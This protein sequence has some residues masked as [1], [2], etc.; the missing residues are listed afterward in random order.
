MYVKGASPFQTAPHLTYL[1]EL[2]RAFLQI[3]KKIW[4]TL[5]VYLYATFPLQHNT[6]VYIHTWDGIGFTEYVRHVCGSGGILGALLPD[7]FSQFLT[8]KNVTEIPFTT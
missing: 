7:T 3:L 4:I 5:P 6:N 8:L 1:N 2:G